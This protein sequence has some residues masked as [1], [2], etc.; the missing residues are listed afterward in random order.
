MLGGIVYHSG[1]AIFM[2]AGSFSYAMMALY[3]GLLLGSDFDAI[4]KRTLQLSRAIRLTSPVPLTVLYDG[5]CRLCI[6]SIQF[7]KKMDWLHLLQPVN[8]RDEPARLRVAPNLK[9]QD[10]NRALRVP[11]EG[12][13]RHIVARE[14]VQ[15]LFVRPRVEGGIRK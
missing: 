9:L 4:R 2:D 7:L 13:L 14:S 6:R 10:L 3:C 15:M 11:T 5:N 8:F 1:I 12:N